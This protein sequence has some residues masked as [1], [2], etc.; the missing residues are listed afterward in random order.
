MEVDIL[1]DQ[2]CHFNKA[3]TQTVEA[4]DLVFSDGTDLTCV[5][6]S[7]CS[8]HWDLSQNNVLNDQQGILYLAFELG[9]PSSTDYVQIG[10]VRLTLEHD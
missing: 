6:G 2:G 9:F 5:P 4:G 3:E 8:K 7:Q 1:Q 10:G